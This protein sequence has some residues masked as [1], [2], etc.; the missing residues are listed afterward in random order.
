MDIPIASHSGQS[1]IFEI[2]FAH[3]DEPIP[4]EF[5]QFFPPISPLALRSE[6][7]IRKQ[8]SRKMAYFLLHQLAQKY[9]LDPHLFTQIQRTESGRPYISDQRVDFNI[10]HSGDWVAV[11]FS[12]SEKGQKRVG[13]DIEHPQKTRQYTNLLRYYATAQEISEIED[14]SV[15]P[16]LATLPDRFYLSW[17]LR[18]AILKSQGIGI[19]KLSEVYHQLEKQHITSIHAPKGQLCFHFQLPF[20]LAY[21]FEQPLSMLSLPSLFQWK[22]GKFNPIIS[23]PFIHYQV[24]QYA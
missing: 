7:L 20:Y 15:L 1:A 21:F 10:S 5:L 4:T 14:F 11:I 22:K 6:R 17:C 12:F 13:I 16:Q 24:N 19:I 9:G 3:N 23:S 8:K 18:E 2:V